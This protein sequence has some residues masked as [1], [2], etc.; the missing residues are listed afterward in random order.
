MKL[1]YIG[2]VPRLTYTSSVAIHE[3]VFMHDPVS[4]GPTWQ[5]P[6]VE[7]QNPLDSYRPVTLRISRHRSILARH[8]PIS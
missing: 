5:F 7:G 6:Y 2:C 8:F 3:A 1:I 4:L